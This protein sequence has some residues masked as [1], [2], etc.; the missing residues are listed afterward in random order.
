MTDVAEGE[1]ITFKPFFQQLT[2]LCI[3]II[4]G[5]IFED[6]KIGQMAIELIVSV[7]ERIPSL[8]DKNKEIFESFCDSI[9][10][11]MIDIE[12]EIDPEWS[13]PPEGYNLD[14]EINSDDNVNFGNISFDRLLSCLGE[15]IMYPLITKLLQGSLQSDNWKYR[16][17]AFM[18]LAQTAEY[19]EDIKKFDPIINELIKHLSHSNPRVRYAT[20][21]CIGLFS[22]DLAPDFEKEYESLLHPLI[23]ML[24]EPVPKVLSHAC[25]ALTNFIEHLEPEISHPLIPQILPKL[26]KLVEEGIS[27]VKENAM[28]CISALAESSDEKFNE[29]LA[30]TMTFLFQSLEKFNKKEYRQFRGQTLECMSVIAS[31]VGKVAFKNYFD[32]LINIMIQ[33]QENVGKNDDPQRYYLLGA[34]QRL[35][36][37][38]QKDFLPYLHKMFPSFIKMAQT[39]SNNNSA[40]NILKDSI[41]E[42]MQDA[43]GDKKELD[44]NTT[45]TEEK[46]AALEMMICFATQL[47]ELFLPYIQQTGEVSLPLLTYLTNSDIRKRA[48]KTLLTMVKVA[49]KSHVGLS[50]LQVLG[51][52]YIDKLQSALSQEYLPEVKIKLI[53]SMTKI[54][55]YLGTSLNIDE[56]KILLSKIWD[57]MKKSKERQKELE[58]E[59][60]E[61][62]EG[63]EYESDELLEEQMYQKKLSDL[64]GMIIKKHPLLTSQIIGDLIAN[65]QKEYLNNDSSIQEKKIGLFMIVDFIEYLGYQYLGKEHF[66]LLSN[67]IIEGCSCYD[68][69]IKHSCIYG[70]GVMAKKGGEGF[71]AYSN[72]SLTI[73]SSIAPSSHPSK[74]KKITERTYEN[75]VSSIGKIIYY[76]SACLPSTQVINEWMKK[77]PLKKDKP[78][79][80]KN[81]KMLYLMISKNPNIILSDDLSNLNLVLKIV[82]KSL[83][84][85]RI[86]KKVKKNWATL[87]KN[88]GNNSQMKVKVEAGFSLLDIDEKKK[89]EKLIKSN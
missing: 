29:Y 53:S 42:M 9:F 65:V 88:W 87:I 66:T 40:E 63:D 8:I 21:Y 22:D 7:I 18:I 81:I 68:V 27:V 45:E 48:A 86:S 36:L 49:S 15:E 80:K 23:Q 76:Q 73:L 44:V 24:N 25:A 89:L 72:Q 69:E 11:I 4:K 60:K 33:L 38:L 13:C 37:L 43:S 41:Q 79:A 52:H 39:S 77:L 74:K 26:I 19:I 62:N 1:P 84:I 2:Q 56:I 59:D 51:R 67:Y 75:A 10:L 64:L 50:D 46:D 83:V 54:F 47:Q 31:A 55:K 30:S 34:W 14:D 6:N 71:S 28:T 61:E 78:E 35:C 17:S 3:S 70:L 16:H 5:K 12:D 82:A 32:I 57:Y 20:L 58:D 85:K